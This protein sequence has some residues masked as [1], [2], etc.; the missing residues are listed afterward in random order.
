MDPRVTELHCI[1]PMANI[2][3][4]LAR[5]ILSYEGVAKLPHH[6]VALQPVQD[7]RDKKQV[8]GGLKLHQYA[9]L[10]FHARNPMMFKRLGE[11][12]ALCVLRVSTRVLNLA[13]TV[14]TDQNAA[15]DYARCFHPS[16]WQML[17]FDAIFAMDWTHPGDQIAFWRHKAQKCAEV[18][19]ANR[20]D[21]AF[22]TGA[23]VVDVA[24]ETHLISLG[25]ALPITVSP[26]LFFR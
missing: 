8:P 26:V 23:Y 19:V 13:G 20:V 6:S 24:A 10:Y 18:L 7:R 22:L 25:F 9:N 4:V 1:M 15:S 14:I 21:P 11:T 2:G 12:N 5:G 16:Q 17:D 3:S